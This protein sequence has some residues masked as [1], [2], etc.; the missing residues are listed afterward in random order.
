M[1]NFTVSRYRATLRFVQADY[2]QRCVEDL[3]VLEFPD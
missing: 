1:D 3:Q 2:V